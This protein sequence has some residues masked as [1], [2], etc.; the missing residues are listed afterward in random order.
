MT[1]T[2]TIQGAVIGA[3]LVF[4][5]SACAKPVYLTQ[6]SGSAA[7]PVAQSEADRAEVAGL[8][9]AHAQEF[10]TLNDHMQSA[11]RDFDLPAVAAAC[12][13]MTEFAHI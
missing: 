5:L 2:R 3:I 13:I 4:A 8:Y 10:S 7:S 11:I 9:S 12:W 6:G 1:K